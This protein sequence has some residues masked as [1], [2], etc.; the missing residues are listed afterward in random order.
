M[1]DTSGNACKACLDLGRN[2]VLIEI[3]E[4]LVR[5]VI[6]PNLGA[7]EYNKRLVGSVGVGVADCDQL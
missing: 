2:C 3:D 1:V 4:R 6:A 5:D 7:V